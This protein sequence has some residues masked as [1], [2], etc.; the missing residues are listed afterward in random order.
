MF[1]KMTVLAL[2]LILAV[3]F[4]ASAQETLTAC[5]NNKTHVL[6]F[7]DVGK[8]CKSNE[9]KI[10]VVSGSGPTGPTGPEGPSG[11]AGATGL[12]GPT[13][14]MGPMGATGPSGAVGAK[15]AQGVQGIQGLTGITGA[16]GPSGP[17]GPAGIQGPEGPEG[18]SGVAGTDGSPG[19]TGPSGVSGPVTTTVV[20]NVTDND[21][22]C[23]CSDI[24]DPDC[25]VG[26]LEVYTATAQ[27]PVG[28]VVIGGGGDTNNL[29]QDIQGVDDVNT[30]PGEPSAD[31]T[32]WV[33]VQAE[34]YDLPCDT[35]YCVQDTTYAVCAPGT[36][37]SI[38]TSVPGTTVDGGDSSDTIPS[39]S[40]NKDQSKK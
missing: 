40:A 38:T 17:S 8:S 34:F 2:G 19:P 25:E 11:P 16:T 26:F 4:D 24:D 1:K 36:T 15:G 32:A 35:T 10:T 7:P 13:G 14:V 22:V 21:C 30:V 29:G 33:T 37:S 5:E 31:G 18:P 23:S 20:Q 6:R 3:A 9:T 28:Q 27:C 39:A 12:A